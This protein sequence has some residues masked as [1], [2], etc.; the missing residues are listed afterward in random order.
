MVHHTNA[1][2]SRERGHSA[3]RGACD[4]MVS[5]TA[6]DDAIHVESSKQRN[7]PPFKPFTLKLVPLADG[8]CVLRSASDVLP[9]KGITT[10]QQKLLDVL[11]ESFLSA[12]ATKSEWQRS[13]QDVPER[14]FHRAAK[15]LVEK[16]YVKQ[17]GSHFRVSEV[18]K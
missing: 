2:G 18:P 3:M 10:Q 6:V 16:G 7:G 1:S 17:T 11:R 9:G 5:L 8:G 15:V 4:F 13:C 14:T 12:G